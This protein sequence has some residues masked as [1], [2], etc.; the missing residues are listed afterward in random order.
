MPT[1]SKITEHYFKTRDE[2]SLAA[3]QHIVEALVRQLGEQDRASLVVTGGS[4]PTPCYTTLARVEMPWKRVDVLMSDDRWVPP[5]HDD[6]NEKLVR[7]TLLQ[8]AAA[9]AV[10][11]PYFAADVTVN[12]RCEQFEAV[13]DDL[14]RPFACSL[15]GMGEDGHIASLFP[16]AE[17]FEQGIDIDGTTQCISVSTAASPHAR[18]SLTLSA[19]LQSTVIV[20]LFFGDSKRDVYEQAK[21]L[22]TA[23][24]VSRLL[25]QDRVPVYAFWAP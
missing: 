3:A 1:A 12:D 14:A 25:H 21:T 5:T 22:P 8:G 20:L 17:N 23:Y 10:L 18:I 15:L 24:P 7:E 4:S 6:S 11:H 13:L 16:D 19:L 2:A 9:D